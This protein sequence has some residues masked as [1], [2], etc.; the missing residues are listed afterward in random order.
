MQKQK[1]VAADVVK[2]AIIVAA[3]E[4]DSSNELVSVHETWLSDET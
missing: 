3:A 2:D 4:S 1:P